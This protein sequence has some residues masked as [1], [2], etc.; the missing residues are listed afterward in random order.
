MNKRK[1]M[2]KTLSDVTDNGTEQFFET[3]Q[4]D[5]KCTSLYIANRL[6]NNFFLHS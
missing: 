6:Y 4:W 5:K 3:I 1:D 2:H